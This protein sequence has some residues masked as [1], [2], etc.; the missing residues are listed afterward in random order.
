MKSIF[1]QPR[2]D[3]HRLFGDDG[4]EEPTTE[5]KLARMCRRTGDG[6]ADDRA[7]DVS[8]ERHA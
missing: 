7:E 2:T 1:D 3:L 4:A 8:V 5:E 6:P